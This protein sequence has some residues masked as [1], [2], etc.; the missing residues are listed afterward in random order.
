M[1]TIPPEDTQALIGSSATFTCVAEAEPTPTFQWEFEGVVIMD[2][3]RYDIDTTS[4]ESA[5]T[6][7]DVVASDD[8]TYTCSAENVHGRDFASA[9]L[10]VLCKWTSSTPISFFL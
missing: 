3:D 7:S 5:L 2:V 9:N 10:Q 6:I 4:T 8:G 1:I